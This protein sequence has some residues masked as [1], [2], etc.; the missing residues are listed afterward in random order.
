MSI[1]KKITVLFFC[2]CVFFMPVVSQAAP[3]YFNGDKNLVFVFERGG[4]VEYLDLTSITSYYYDPPYYRLG[5]N[6]LLY[7]EKKAKIVGRANVY[8][9]YYLDT[10]QI[11]RIDIAA[12]G[13]KYGPIN[14]NTSTSGRHNFKLATM[15]WKKA[16]NMDWK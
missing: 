6:I 5:G 16:Y 4:A 1:L 2:C 3:K 9:D 10:H 12:N 8:Y 15:I 13:K 11:Y 14:Q 7:S